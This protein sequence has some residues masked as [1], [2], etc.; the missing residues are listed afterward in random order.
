MNRSLMSLSLM[1]PNLKNPSLMNLSLTQNRL[2]RIRMNL[3]LM[4]PNLMN[5]NLTSRIL[6]S[7]I[8]MSRILTPQRCLRHLQDLLYK[9]IDKRKKGLRARGKTVNDGTSLTLPLNRP[10]LVP[11]VRG[12][13]LAC[14]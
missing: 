6:T 2:S 10:A 3:N 4:N 13:E 9:Q 14:L 12:E 1:N 5:P 8:L 11:I 7:R